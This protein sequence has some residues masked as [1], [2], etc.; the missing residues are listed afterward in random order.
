MA[1]RGRTFIGSLRRP[2]SLHAVHYAVPGLR[3]EFVQSR[4][5]F[6]GVV[7]RAVLLQTTHSG[8]GGV[9]Q[10]VGRILRMRG[11]KRALAK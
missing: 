10:T 4:N 5:Q 9:R 2:V 7:L 8:P 3:N 1:Y 6:I 11:N